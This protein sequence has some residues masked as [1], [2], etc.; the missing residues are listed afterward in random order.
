MINKEKPWCVVIALLAISVAACV[1]ADVRTTR[2]GDGDANALQE[3]LSR[4]YSELAFRKRSEGNLTSARHFEQKA[5]QAADGREVV[6]DR[7]DIASAS[8]EYARL[9]VALKSENV[10]AAV[11]ARAQVMFDCLLDER[12]QA[13]DRDDIR[14]CEQEFERALAIITRVPDADGAG[15]S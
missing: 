2:V 12:Q 3:Q 10:D 6:P 9:S 8:T 4:Q 7:P 1:N 11:R 5:I 13:V 15:A 14:A